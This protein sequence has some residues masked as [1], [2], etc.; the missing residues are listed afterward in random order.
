MLSLHFHCLNLSEF[1][2]FEVTTDD[3]D[4]SKSPARELFEGFLT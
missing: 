3:K 4:Y 2:R 1:A